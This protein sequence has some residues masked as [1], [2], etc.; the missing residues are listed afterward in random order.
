MKKLSVFLCAM[1]LLF[2]VVGNVN[3]WTQFNDGGVHNIGYIIMDDVWVDYN[4]HGAQTTVNFLPGGGVGPGYELQAH[5]D[6]IINIVGGS[7]GDDFHLYNRSQSSV[8]SG[9]INDELYSYDN[10]QVT[11]SGGNLTDLRSYDNSQL[12]VS[13]GDIGYLRN[14]DNSQVTVSGGDM[15]RLYSYDN[16]QTAMSGG[17]IGDEII[18]GQSGILTFHG[19]DFAVDGTLFGYGELTSILGGSYDDEP[20][21]VL[22]GTLASGEAIDNII[23]IGHSA[24]IVL[25]PVPIPSAIWLLGSGLIGII[26]FRRK[27]RKEA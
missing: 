25:S 12:V 17:I 23:R 4:T 16:S 5:E 11:V 3:A 8:I 27:L 19:L 18:L 9:I 24:K 6:S 13:G 7:I 15:Y 26:G 14:N 21:R 20:S 10:S 2:G 22:S 1:V